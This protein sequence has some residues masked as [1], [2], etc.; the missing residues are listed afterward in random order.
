MV[1]QRKRIEIALTDAA[2]KRL[3]WLK[4]NTQ[5]K[6]LTEVV[7]DALELK[8]AVTKLQLAG[9][10]VLVRD[11]RQDCCENCSTR[12][13]RPRFEAGVQLIFGVD[14]RPERVRPTRKH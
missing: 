3:D 5:A 10:T 1:G 4:E 12:K 9:E 11:A 6:N 7:K 13:K 14:W 2:A 8:E